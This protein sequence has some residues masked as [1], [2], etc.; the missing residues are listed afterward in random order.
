[1]WSERSK[2]TRAISFRHWPAYRTAF[3]I[4]QWHELVPQMVLTLN[5][6]LQS[7]VAPNVSAYAYHHGNFDYDRMPLA[8]MGCAVQ[9]HIKP[10]RRKS[11]GEHSSNGWYLKMSPDHCRCHIIF[12]KATQAKQISDTVYFKHKHI[13]QPTLTPEDRIVQAIQDLSNAIKGGKKLGS[14]TQ[15]DA[16]KGLTDALRPGNQM[17]L[18]AHS[19]RVHRL[20]HLQ[21]CKLTHLQGCSLTSAATKTCPLMWIR[22]PD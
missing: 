14:S 7:H 3:P 15:I 8:P 6:L 4:H 5:L 13:T 22:H 9:F 19:P 10:N 2:P 21:G 16:I 20:T 17:P 11:W 1:M 18:Q 12:V